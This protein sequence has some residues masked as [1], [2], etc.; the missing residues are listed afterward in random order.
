[1]NSTLLHCLFEFRSCNSKTTE[2]DKLT[3]EA[4]NFLL[5]SIPHRIIFKLFGLGIISPL[6]AHRE[7]LTNK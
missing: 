1:M 3:T 4:D 2:A 7:D 5:P 6:I